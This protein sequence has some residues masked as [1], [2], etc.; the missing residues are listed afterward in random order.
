MAE[1]LNIQQPIIF[2]E[3]IAHYE[4][5]AHL[6][7]A[8]STFNNSDEIRIAVQHQDLCLL[9]SKSTL[10]IYGKLTKADGTAVSATT[11]MVS[12]AVCHMF[13][14]I[15]Y[16]LNAVEIDRNKNVGITSLMKGYASLSPA[17]QNTLE[18]AGWIIAG[19]VNK[20]HNDHG[21]FDVS[22]PLSLLLGF[23]EDYQKVIINAKHE[24][25]LIRSNADLNAYV[26]AAP[27]AGANPEAV[28]ITLQK[29]EWI[30][31]YVTMSDKQKIQVLNFITNDPA[32]SISFRAWELYEY[33]LLPNTSKHIWTVK[34]STQLEKPRF[35]ILGFQTERKN[36]ATKNASEFD[37]CD[38][39]DIKL[40][41]NSQSYPYGN[42]NL[43]IANN[44]YALLYD[45]YINFQISYYGKEPE[46][47]LMKKQFL[48]KAPLY[49]IDCSKQNE[50]IKSGPVD[51]RLEFE[52]VNQFP[53]QTA[54]YCLIIHDR[55]IEY[56]PISSSVRKLI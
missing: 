47:L 39:R 26:V 3:S 36:D 2:D 6:P 20:L 22:V 31:P 50:S 11:Q 38:I 44:Q 48:E 15:R 10:H 53:N 29:I 41:L 51:I 14:E 43:N 55:I 32:I 25:I 16:E 17:Q 24:L 49:I 4:A 9:P 33:P 12:M 7:Y 54:A 5:H 30:V 34:T 45:M 18:N 40:F 19:N 28:K 37:H 56:N 52:S 35:V 23:A 42:L 27:A 1:I 13:E 46:P 8:S 21:Y